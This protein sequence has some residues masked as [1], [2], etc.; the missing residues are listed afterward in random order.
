MLVC[1]EAKLRVY[2]QMNQPRLVHSP[3]NMSENDD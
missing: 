1:V 3:S 2:L